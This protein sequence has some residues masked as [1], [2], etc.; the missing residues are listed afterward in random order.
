MTLYDLMSS[1]TL[2]GNI[3]IRVMNDD[4]E[5]VK[6]EYFDSV[7]DLECCEIF[8]LEDME[9]LEVQYMYAENACM[10]IELEETED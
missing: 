7:D 5:A 1:M 10:V 4:G 9:N 6:T 3:E 8:R 2:Q